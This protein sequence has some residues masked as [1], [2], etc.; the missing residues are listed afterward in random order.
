MHQNNKKRDRK[1]GYFEYCAIKDGYK[2]C[3]IGTKLLQARKSIAEDNNCSYILSDTSVLADSAIKYH[4]KN[5]FKIVGYESFHSTNYWSYVF[6]LQLK[7]R[8]I[9][10]IG[11]F[12]L[13]RFCLSYVFIK[14][15][16][17][18]NGDDTYIGRLYKQII[19]KS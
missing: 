15:T 1:F 3:G 8:S 11:A 13:V 16:R 17:T 19:C 12:R 6:R 14:V 18:V 5:G 10:D 4:K 7:G 9:W 2:H